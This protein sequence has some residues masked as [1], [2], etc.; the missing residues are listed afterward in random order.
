ML[1]CNLGIVMGGA[2]IRVFLLCHHDPTSPGIHMKHICIILETGHEINKKN[3]ASINSKYQ[4]QNHIDNNSLTNS[5]NESHWVIFRRGMI[6]SFL[7][8]YCIEKKV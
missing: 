7:S 4:Y 2:E 1:G 3:K 6:C 8:V 5:F